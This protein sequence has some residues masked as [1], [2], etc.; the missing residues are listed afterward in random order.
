MSEICP[1][2]LLLQSIIFSNFPRL[3]V[4]LYESGVEYLSRSRSRPESESLVLELGA[5]NKLETINPGQLGRRLA[6][7]HNIAATHA[8]TYCSTDYS[9]DYS[10]RY[11]TDTLHI[12]LYITLQILYSRRF[13]T[14]T[15]LYALLYRFSIYWYIDYHMSYLKVTQHF[16]KTRTLFI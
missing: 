2:I 7:L 14:D 1:H 13:S 10:I 4:K 15:L 16:H 5:K 12:T 3:C 8:S 6:S 11:S 9:T